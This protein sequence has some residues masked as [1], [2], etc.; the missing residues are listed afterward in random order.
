MTDLYKKI[1]SATSFLKKKI[2]N[3]P[4]FAIVA[5]TGLSGIS[6]DI[7]VTD[8]IPYAE[9]PF[10]PQ[11][12]VVGHEGMM[13]VGML[14]GKCVLALKGRFHYYEGYSMEEVTFYVRVL[15]LLGVKK[16]IISN[17]SGAVNPKI[18]AGDIVLIRDH[19]NM[20]PENPLRGIHDKR[21]GKRFPAMDKVYDKT[22]LALAT[23]IAHAEK[24]DFHTGVY[25]ALQGPNLETQAE[26]KYLGFI[27]GDV[28]GMSTVPEVIVA[29]QC[30]I[31]V[32]C[33]SL[34][35][36]NPFQESIATDIEEIIS[37]GKQQEIKIRRLVKRVIEGT[38]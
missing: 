5:G 37:I 35:T 28:V 36:N 23:Q 12:T 33:I 7:V 31:Q 34:C 15:Y 38:F 14:G 21:W 10:F 6:D 30:E 26:Y 22:L 4:D 16:L 2:K 3:I 24:L 25:V 8:Y 13:V 11:P 1:L 18:N 27:G 17:A 19:I 29:A 32:L 9:I 20:L